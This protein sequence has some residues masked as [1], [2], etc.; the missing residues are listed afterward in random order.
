M[1]TINVPENVLKRVQ[2]R[3][4]QF[5]FESVDEYVACLIAAD[6]DHGDE[7]DTAL[8]KKFTPAV[9]AHLDETRLQI[10]HGTE[11]TYAMTDVQE[12]LKRKVA[13]WRAKQNP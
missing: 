7:F 13:A 3:A 9:V 11:K 4:T 12:F 2:M 5:G 1:A 6:A 8:E 10:E